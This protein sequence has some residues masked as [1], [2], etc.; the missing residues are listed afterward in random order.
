MGSMAASRA[1][2][3][4]VASPTPYYIRFGAPFVYSRVDPCGQPGLGAGRCST[5]CSRPVTRPIQLALSFA[6]RVL[7]RTPVL[8]F[9]L[10]FV[11]GGE[12][13]QPLGIFP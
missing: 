13:A 5:P 2:P 4:A 3:R 12:G 1:A 7:E 11:I 8:P 6:N 10:S 9:S